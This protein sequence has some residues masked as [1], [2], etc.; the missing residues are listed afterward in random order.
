MKSVIA[1]PK[2]G[3]VTLL[4]VGVGVLGGVVVGVA[5][6]RV[7]CVAVGRGVVSTTAWVGA[8]VGAGVRVGGRVLHATVQSRS[9]TKIEAHPRPIRANRV[10]ARYHCQKDRLPRGGG[11]CMISPLFVKN[12]LAPCHDCVSCKFWNL[13]RSTVLTS[14]N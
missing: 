14:R 10:C 1:P 5:V 7:A 6:G 4:G 12:M 11:C 13:Q 8:C 2:W 3:T 9:A